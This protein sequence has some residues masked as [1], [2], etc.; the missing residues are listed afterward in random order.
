L[1]INKKRGADGKVIAETP[2]ARGSSNN[3]NS[4]NSSGTSQEPVSKRLKVGEDTVKSSPAGGSD[5]MDVDTNEVP[6]TQDETIVPGQH[7]VFVKNIDFSV[8]QE[9]LETVFKKVKCKKGKQDEDVQTPSFVVRLTLST[10]GKSRGMA[11]VDFASQEA[12]DQAMFLHNTV[13]NGRPITI[14][15]YVASA[16]AT[17]DFHPMTI[18]IK[19]MSRDTQEAALKS[20]LQ[21]VLLEAK[22]NEDE[23]D[24]FT[25]IK[26]MKCKRS[27]NSKGQALVQFKSADYV[28][29]CIQAVTKTE[30]LLDG[31]KLIASKSKFPAV[32]EAPI[33][34]SKESRSSV[35]KSGGAS[36][37]SSNLPAAKGKAMPMSTFKPRR[38]AM[39][40]ATAKPKSSLTPTTNSSK[41]ST[42]P[43]NVTTASTAGNDGGKSNS[44]FRKFF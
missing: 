12:A 38:L 14:E 42:S 1:E 18:F 16:F 24:V 36:T 3:N 11:H 28:P 30:K 37:A 15:K 19:N 5:R 35:V 32:V 9:Q 26:L 31:K 34:T 21:D 40:P 6:S 13:I 22:H 20:F 27:G 4:S 23:I 2:M 7:T 44:D 39:N 10:K 29:V 17:A 33:S 43:T 25:A 8:T 41:T